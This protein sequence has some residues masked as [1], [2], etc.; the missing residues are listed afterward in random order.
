M[1]ASPVVTGQST[2]DAVLFG[3]KDGKIYLL[4]VVDGSIKGS[5]TL[6]SGMPVYVSPSYDSV[7]KHLYI[8]DSG[9]NVYKFRMTTSPF[10]G[11]PWTLQLQSGWP[12]NVG[13][14]MHSAPAISLSYRRLALTSYHINAQKIPLLSLHIINMDTGG[15]IFGSETNEDINGQY[16]LPA[17]IITNGWVYVLRDNDANLGYFCTNT[18]IQYNLYD[19]SLNWCARAFFPGNAYSDSSPAAYGYSYGGYWFFGILVGGSDGYLYHY[20][21]A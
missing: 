10:G 2:T 1:T 20:Y 13:G 6:S 15:H 21:R 8:V 3:A 9:G 11:I 14:T 12:V 19:G 18:V 5:Y 4:C 16:I 7:N 17:P